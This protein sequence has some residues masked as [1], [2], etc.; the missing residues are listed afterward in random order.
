MYLARAEDGHLDAI[1]TLVN[2]A[3]RGQSAEAGWTH[4][5]R[6][7]GGQRTDADSLRADLAARPE[8]AILTLSDTEGG[9]AVASVWL[10]P[11][12]DT[13]WSL[14]MLAVSPTRQDGQLGRALIESC[15]AYA[16]T[17]GGKTMKMTVIAGR[18]SLI[19]W[20]QRRGYALTGAEEP[21]PYGDERFGM[22]L[23]DDLKFL[24]LQK[25]L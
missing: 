13:A 2:S 15:E 11:L 3:Y 22:P 20:Y 24:V 25:P 6:L 17:R 4:E 7:L 1:A 18:D 14:G 19:A 8:A 23:T 10:E 12:G 5:A 16:R 9:A 21:F